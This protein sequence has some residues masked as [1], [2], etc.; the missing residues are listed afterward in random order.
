MNYDSEKKFIPPFY[1][2][3]RERGDREAH[4]GFWR[5]D[6]VC[7]AVDPTNTGCAEKAPSHSSHGK[8][9]GLSGPADR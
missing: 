9:I 7:K 2:H 8:L 1:P 6:G 3:K 5:P 4:G